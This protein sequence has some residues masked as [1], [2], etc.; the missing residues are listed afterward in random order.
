MGAP[1][2]PP[3][4]HLGTCSHQPHPHVGDTSPA[5]SSPSCCTQSPT[6]EPWCWD[7][8]GGPLHPS[9]APLCPLMA[10]PEPHH[11][12]PSAA[13]IDTPEPPPGPT[14][15]QP[16]A[17]SEPPMTFPVSPAPWP[18]LCLPMATHPPVQGSARGGAQTA[19][20]PPPPTGGAGGQ[21]LSPAHGLHPALWGAQGL[22]VTPSLSLSPLALPGKTHGCG[23]GGV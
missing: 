10:N 9:M 20:T 16:M 21:G 1:A 22:R 3:R 23:R 6:V 15:C 17:P 19:R 5:S 18:P 13:P 8:A 12:L 11:D 4:P 7:P 14:L 2:P